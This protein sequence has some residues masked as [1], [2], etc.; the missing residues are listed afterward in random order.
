VKNHNP[1]IRDINLLRTGDRIAFPLIDG[2][3]IHPDSEQIR[4]D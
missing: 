2:M 4:S 1:H 3:N